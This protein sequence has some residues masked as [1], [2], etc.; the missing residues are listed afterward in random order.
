MP[1]VNIRMPARSIITL[2]VSRFTH[3]VSRFTSH[4]TLE[5]LLPQRLKQH[6]RDTI[7]QVQ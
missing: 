2:Q 5:T 1:R 7:G 4:L 6:Q 3:H